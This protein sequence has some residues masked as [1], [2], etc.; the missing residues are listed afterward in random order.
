MNNMY[1]NEIKDNLKNLFINNQDVNKK[2]TEIKIILH[3]LEKLGF[4]TDTL[5][6]M[7]DNV[8]IEFYNFKMNTNDFIKEH[9]GIEV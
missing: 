5:Y 8:G 7:L 6:K 4:N 1:N 2:I 3:N 9:L